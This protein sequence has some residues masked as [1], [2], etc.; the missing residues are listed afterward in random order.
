MVFTT[1]MTRRRPYFFLAALLVLPGIACSTIS[2]PD[3]TQKIANYS[4]EIYMARASLAGA[5]FE[6]YKVLSSGVYQEC[7]MI[8]RGRAVTSQQTILPVLSEVRAEVGVILKALVEQL[9]QKPMTTLPAPGKVD[10]MFD[11]GKFTLLA[12]VDGEQLSVSTTFDEVINGED[13]FRQAFVRLTELLRG[14]PSEPPC[15]NADFYGIGR[16]IKDS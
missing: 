15:K 16:R 4:L 7:G 3:P 2:S 10:D 8:R 6:Q 11:E 1:P 12:T 13:E 9:A 14:V 5:E